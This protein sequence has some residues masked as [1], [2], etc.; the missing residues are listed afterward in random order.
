MALAKRIRGIESEDTVAY[1]TKAQI[2]SAITAVKVLAL[3]NDEGVAAETATTQAR[4]T[5]AI[6]KADGEIDGYAQARYAVPMDAPVGSLIN[7]IS[8]SLAVY[9]LHVRRY[10]SFGLPEAVKDEY[11][12][13]VK[14]LEKINQGKLDLG[15]EPTPAASSKMGATD[16]GPT[17]LFVLPSS[18]TNGTLG[19]F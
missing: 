17:N 14:Q 1:S 13:R 7:V 10:G 19:E 3:S 16:S 15:V 12:M 6:R 11:L 9:Y 8:I 2:E 18:T 4:I 5:E